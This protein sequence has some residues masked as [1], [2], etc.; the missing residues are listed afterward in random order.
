[1]GADIHLIRKIFLMEGMLITIIGAFLGLLSGSI[2]CWIQQHYEIIKMSENLAYPVKFQTS[3]ILL[4]LITVLSIGF[5]AAWYPV[6]IFTKKHLA[7]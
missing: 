4:I 1:M 2:L 6:K 7:L 3:D 5:V